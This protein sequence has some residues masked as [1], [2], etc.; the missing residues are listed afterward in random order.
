ML[1]SSSALAKGWPNHSDYL[2]SKGAVE[3]FARCLA[4]DE[5]APLVLFLLTAECCPR[6]LISRLTRDIAAGGIET[7]MYEVA[8]KSD[9]NLMRYI[10]FSMLVSMQSSISMII[11]ESSLRQ[12]ALAESRWAVEG[13]FLRGSFCVQS[14]W[15]VDECS[16]AY[17]GGWGFFV[18]GVGLG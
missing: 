3:A 5:S 10:A 2:G 13:C 11:C 4:V 8:R 18:S 6:K 16:G 12:A 9:A 17:Y 1:T 15:R 14:G 7:T